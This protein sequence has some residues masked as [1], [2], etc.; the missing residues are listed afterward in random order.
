[1]ITVP[2][3]KA[4]ADGIEVLIDIESTKAIISKSVNSK[5]KSQ[6]HHQ[7]WDVHLA[8]PSKVNLQVSWCTNKPESIPQQ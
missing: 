7:H 2:A 3:L 6:S 5:C 1:V 4:A 8:N